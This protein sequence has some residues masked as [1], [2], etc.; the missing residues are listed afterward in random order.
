MKNDSPKLGTQKG[1][2]VQNFSEEQARAYFEN[3][4][5]P[6]GPACVHCGSVNVYRVGRKDNF[7]S[8]SKDHRSHR[9]GLY[10]CR[11]KL[12]RQ[13]FSVTVGTVMEDSH[14]SLAIWARAFHFM[15]AS[16]KGVS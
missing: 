1:Q 5:W 9:T 12:C 3:L 7:V 14:L 4:R 2:N 6:N 15:C 10:E 11:E 8:K 16:K 13:Q